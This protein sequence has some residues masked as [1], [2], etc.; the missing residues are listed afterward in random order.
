MMALHELV[1]QITPGD[2]EKVSDLLEQAGALSIAITDAHDEPIF[3]PDIDTHPLWDHMVLTA[4]FDKEINLDSVKSYNP[5]INN[6]PEQDWAKIC[7]DNFKPVCFGNTLWICPSWHTVITLDPGLAF[8]T[9]SHPTTQLCLEWLALNQKNLTDKI[10]IDYGTGSGILAI[11]AMKLGAKKVYAVDIDPQ[12][13]DATRQNA[14]KNNVQLEIMTPQEL[15]LQAPAIKADIVLANILANPLI[16][17]A[18]QLLYYLPHTG[19][20]I[21]SGILSTQI[22]SVCK[23]YEP[24]IN[25]NKPVI[26][27][28]WVRLEG[29]KS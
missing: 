19:T 5:R 9:G 18:S 10:M 11:S 14:L 6:L 16:E 8:G 20:V 28:D 29:I 1:L 15:T 27:D 12:A 13:L 25:F 26:Q 17:L 2:Y 4:L 24:F 7:Q 22:E 3:E 23:A 21:L